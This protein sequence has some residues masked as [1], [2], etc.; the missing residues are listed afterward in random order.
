MKNV[1]IDGKE[2]T[3]GLKISARLEQRGDIN[4]IT[5]SDRLRKDQSARKEALNSCDIAFLCLP[6]PAA[7]EAVVMIENPW[8]KIIDAS[9]AHRTSTGWTYGFPELSKTQ[10]DAVCNSNRT[11]VP[12]CHA[13]GFIALV[14]PLVS[15]GILPS[16]ALISCVSLT[17]YSGGGKKMIEQYDDEGRDILLDAPRLYALSQSHK[18]LPEMTYICGLKTSPIFLPVVSDY[19]SGMLVTVPLFPR[20]LCGK[21]SVEDIREVYRRLYTGPVVIYKDKMDEDGFLSASSLSGTDRMEV[22]V[23]GNDDRIVLVARFDNLGKG[24]SGAAIECMNLMTGLA[25]ETGLVL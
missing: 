18:H 15:A 5:L 21:A 19:Y 4:L 9:T 24:A 8:V 13:G 17:G 22:S 2:G 23:V 7:R 3:T 25:P 1:F 16:D 11:A 10:R 6:D 20:M 14:Q 12:G